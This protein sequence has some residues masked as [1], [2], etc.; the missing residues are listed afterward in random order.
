MSLFKGGYEAR[1]ILDFSKGKI[2]KNFIG[3]LLRKTEIIEYDQSIFIDN[4]ISVG[5]YKIHLF[6]VEPPSHEPSP[7][8]KCGEFS[9]AI[10]EVNHKNN[11]S[12]HI[13]LSKDIRFK[14]QYW[15]SLSYKSQLKIK[16]LIDIIMYVKRLNNL[17]LFL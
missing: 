2:S 16:N 9:V 7:L 8:K 5:M 3:Q 11:V 15:V 10:F 12:Q 4:Y 17:K 14:N 13:S 1:S 6:F